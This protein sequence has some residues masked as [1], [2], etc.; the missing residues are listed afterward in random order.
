LRDIGDL[1][2]LLAASASISRLVV[3]GWPEREMACK[4]YERAIVIA[5]PILLPLAHHC[6]FSA[7]RSA[8]FRLNYYL[9]ERNLAI[10]THRWQQGSTKG[11]MRPVCPN[12]S[13][14][15]G[16]GNECQERPVRDQAAEQGS[17]KSTFGET[18]GAR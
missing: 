9:I 16:D 10:V 14:D 4:I 6:G 5:C 3:D 17:R 1:F 2:E 15:K 13:P 8:M 11:Q 12:P 7:E 18:G